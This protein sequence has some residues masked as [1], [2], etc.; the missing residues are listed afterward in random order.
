MEDEIKV[1]DKVIHLREEKSV[2]WI[3]HNDLALIDKKGSMWLTA[4]STCKLV[5]KK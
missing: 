4:R 2:K 5:T 1:G 3:R